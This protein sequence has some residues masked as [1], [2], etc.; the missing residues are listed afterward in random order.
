MKAR[1]TLVKYLERMTG[2]PVVL[3]PV[4][5][6]RL[7]G[8]PAFLA[9]GYA[10]YDWEWMGQK[11]VLMEAKDGKADHSPAH[12]KAHLGFLV[13][14]FKRHVAFVFQALDAYRRDRLV[15]LGVPFVVPDRQF[16]IPP[17]V[18]LVEKFQR[19]DPSTRLSAPAQ[20]VLLYQLLR[21]PPDACHLNQWA[22]W[23]GYSNMTMGKVRDEL[24]AR[25]LCAIGP[26]E[27]PRGLNFLRHGRELWD[28]ARPVLRSPIRRICWALWQSPPPGLLRAG[29]S[30]LSRLT[31]LG[32]DAIPSYACRDVKWRQLLKSGDVQPA[33]HSSDAS[34]R[35]ECWYYDPAVLGSEGAVD[36][37]SLYLSLAADPDER[38]RSAADSLLGEVPW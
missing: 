17:F 34:A 20:V 7:K 22:E 18:S 36:R 5:P 4:V 1:A 2:H 29:I 37:L 38:V 27:K 25:D 6:D 28:A 31:M 9:L 30:D 24:A 12:L 23:V 19:V 33:G 13:E 26:G 10:F 15:R 8:L 21:H 14:H 16:F 11:F 32:E 35:V 3:H